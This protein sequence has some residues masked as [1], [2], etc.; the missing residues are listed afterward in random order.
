MTSALQIVFALSL[1]ALNGFFVAAEF[2]LARARLTRLDTAAA[3][4]SRASRRAAEQVRHIDRYLAACQLGITLASLGLGWVG[5]PAFADVLEPVL[6]RIGL[7]EDAAVVVGFAIAFAIITTLHVVLGE[8]APKS[9]AIQRAEGTARVIARPLEWFRIMFAP[10]IALFN[11][12]GNATVRLLGVA[13]ASEHELASTP[14]DLELLIAES[15][16]S[17]TVSPEEAEMLRG[18]FHLAD[19]QARDV[20]TPRPAVVVLAAEMAPDVGLDAALATPHS[21]FPVLA[22]EDTPVG[23]VHVADLAREVRQGGPRVVGALCREVPVTSESRPLDQLLE[24]LRHDR[25]SLSL[26][27]DEYG[28][29]AGVVSVEDIVEEVVGEIQDERDPESLVQRRGDGVLVAHGLTA[30]DDLRDHGVQIHDDEVT[31][32]GGLVLDRLGRPAHVGEIVEVHGYRLGV[33]EVD[34]TRIVRV[35]IE[36]LAHDGPPG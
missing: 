23:V 27:L 1:V 20:M 28:Q 4:G 18:V 24:Q 35:R 16:R 36:P 26:V 2:S 15:S 22:A 13:P 10:L 21:R 6:T 11:G 32:V 25:T 33:E 3:E 29:L 12:A 9:L 5:E 30:L 7:A 8:L 31:S 14:E 17:G 34:G 19:R